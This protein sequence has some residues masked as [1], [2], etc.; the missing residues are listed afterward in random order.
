MVADESALMLLTRAIA[1]GDV[2]TALR[3]LAASPSLAS[4][5]L[6]VGASRQAANDFFLDE[7][8]H[9][10][11]A[12][13][14]ALHIAAASY[15]LPVAR[16]LVSSGADVG[17]KN[18]RGAQPLHYAADGGPGSASWDPDAQAATIAYLIDAGA[19]PNATD[20]SGV[21]PLHRAVRTR[22]AAAVNALLDGGA[23]PRRGNK[24]GST[25]MS[26]AS[27]NTGRSG[28]G[29]PQSKEQQREIMRLLVVRCATP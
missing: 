1:A 11:Y 3:L 26:L 24:N 25:P 28:S 5:Q 9:Y 19:D 18:R 15:R 10:V 29:S 6:E 8:R 27:Q 7:I 22:C 12:G 21:A 20:S 13:D 14:T 2:P 16:E 4:A 23:D 17:A